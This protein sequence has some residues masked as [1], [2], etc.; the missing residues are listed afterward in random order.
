VPLAAVGLLAVAGSSRAPAFTLE[1]SSPPARRCAH[2]DDATASSIVQRRALRCLI[3]T[4]RR[5]ARLRP[6]RAS[7]LLASSAARKAQDVRRCGALAHAACGRPPRAAAAE[8]GYPGDRWWGEILYG[9][10]DPVRAPEI[11]VQR[12]LGSSSHRQ[13]LLNPRW[14]E[15]GVGLL[16][17]HDVELD[18]SIWVVHFG[19]RR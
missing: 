14:T 17:Y 8:A 6:L 9:A 4:V 18:R 10:T 2:A 11:A 12:W 15:F 1:P 7:S 16:R 13:T 3:N 5:H 19:T